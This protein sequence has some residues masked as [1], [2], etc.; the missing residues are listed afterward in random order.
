M[1]NSYT[2]EEA[3]NKLPNWIRQRSR[4]CKGHVQTY[5]VHMRDPRK[6]LR[7]MGWK[8]F[9]YFQL[10]F[11]GNI[12]LPLVNP[13]LWIVTI[14]TMVSP[15]VFDF[16]FFYPIV[17]VCVFNL[18][19]GNGVYILLHM[20]PY[21]IRKHYT[22]IPLALIIPLYWMLISVGDWRG[23]VQLVT[24]PFYWEKTQHGLSHL[25]GKVEA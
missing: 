13:V 7:E 8:Q 3:N 25:H 15:G 4:W 18:F 14:L 10:T 20:G 16:L 2:Y 21:V 1:L 17:Y 19:V 11:G 22:S 6:L 12:F 23:A 5:L 24:K 9:F